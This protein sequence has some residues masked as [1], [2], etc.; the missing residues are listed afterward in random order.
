MGIYPRYSLFDV[1][2]GKEIED[3]IEEGPCGIKL[4]AGGSG[5]NQI[6]DLKQ[7][8]RDIFLRK[9]ESLDGFDYILMDTGAG[10]NRS[11]L[12]FIACCEEVIIITTPEPTSL[13]DAY[14]LVKAADHFKIK[15]KANV[16]V[17][18]AYTKEEGKQTFNNFKSAIDKFL[19]VE[20]C[21][22]GCILDDKKLVQGV[23]EQIPFIISY[24]NSDAA[25]CIDEISKGYMD[26]QNF[27]TEENFGAKKLFKKLFNLF[28]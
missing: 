26:E 15:S 7:E 13:T 28:S 27:N 6:E 1:I 2:R 22:L 23:R 8:E 19:K 21:Y 10:I 16:I 25:K 9:L 24:P 11:V 4:L 12:A 18:R 3:I 14:S 5:I 17:N 20:V